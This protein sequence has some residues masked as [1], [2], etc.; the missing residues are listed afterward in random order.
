MDVQLA[1]TGAERLVLLDRHRLVA[2]ED[3]QVVEQGLMD[4]QELLVAEL[5]GKI[6]AEHFGADRGGELRTSID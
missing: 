5:T 4:F 2:E 6:D 1:E 3:D